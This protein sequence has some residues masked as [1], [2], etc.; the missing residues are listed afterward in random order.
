MAAGRIGNG[1]R[2]SLGS[3]WGES[4][5]WGVGLGLGQGWG[6]RAEVSMRVRVPNL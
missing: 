5:G 1:R 6:V 2:S 3:L 4:E